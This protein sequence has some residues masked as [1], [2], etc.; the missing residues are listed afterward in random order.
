MVK[1]AEAFA[2]EDH[3]RRE[4][5]EARNQAD[6]LT[7][8]VDTFLKDNGEKIADADKA[9]LTSKNDELKQL[10]KDESA[11]PDAL[12]SASDSLL[13]V[14]QRVSQSMHEQAAQA[15]A[16]AGAGGDEASVPD[17]GADDGDEDVV[18]GEIVDEGGTS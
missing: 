14:W 13:Q 12:R 18:E 15:Q 17:S 2:A 1:E 6:Q 8:Q 16:A 5:A 3:K 10:L 11:D 4:A 7:Y 9:E